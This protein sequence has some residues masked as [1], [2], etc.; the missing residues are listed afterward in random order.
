MTKDHCACIR[1]GKATCN[2]E[3]TLNITSKNGNDVTELLW[4][5]KAIN[6][7]DARDLGLFQSEYWRTSCFE[8]WLIKIECEK[9]ETL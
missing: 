1:Y 9:S 8:S 5:L 6:S 2:T 3:E 7:M 4:E